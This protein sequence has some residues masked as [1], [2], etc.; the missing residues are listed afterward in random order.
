MIR[1]KSMKQRFAV[2]M[3]FPVGLSLLG[4]GWA[5]FT[6]ARNRML[7][8]WGEATI[9]KLQRAAHHVDMRLSK[10]KEMLNLFTASAGMPHAAGIQKLVI[11]RLRQFQW[12]ADVDLEW[13]RRIAASNEHPMTQGAMQGHAEAMKAGGRLA[14]TSSM[15]PFHRGS[16]VR[17]TSPR[18]DAVSGGETV[19]LLSELKNADDQTIGRIEVNLFFSHLIDVVETTGWWKAQKAFLVDGTGRILASNVDDPR[20]AL[21]GQDAAMTQAIL[22][23]T[24]TLPFGTVFGKGKPPQEVGGFYRLSE[25][26]WV[27]IVIAPGREI[28]SSIIDFRFY[29]FVFGSIFIGVILIIIRLVTGK[30]VAA[31]RGVSDAARTVAEGDYSVSLPVRSED[32][33]GD[34]IRSFNTM[35]GQLKERAR[36]K[37]SLNLASEVQ[38]NLFPEKGLQVST[39]DVAGRSISCD[40]TGG[41]YF[42]YLEGAEFSEDR[43]GI[44]VGDVS[45][46]GIAA[47]LLMT[48]ARALIRSRFMQGG[49][50]ADIVT[51]VNRLLCRDTARTSN[52]MTLFLCLVDGQSKDIRW[53]RAGHDPAILYDARK[54]LFSVLDGKGMA[55]GV[56]ETYRYDEFVHKGWYSGDILI[57]GTDGIWDTENPSGE[58]FGKARLREIVRRGSHETAERILTAITDALAAFRQDRVQEDDVTLVV[59]KA[60]KGCL[61]KRMNNG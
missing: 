11:Q 6:Y 56:D 2:Y 16:T 38:Q 23:A 19:S 50:L 20:L 32:E 24:Q 58:R 51:G 41:D 34:L 9:L 31:I 22:A 42:D 5:A 48:T 39:L 45:D 21:S 55:L 61:P 46:H 33:I 26:P 54:D 30:T 43:I 13:T 1:F 4:M 18:F 8:E 35:V 15:M 57:I 12:V 44:A 40:E 60:K 52:F 37:Y 36:M 3:L 25:A 10:P 49:K 17:I 7:A 59:V 29:Y 28:L 27:L 14:G 53:V 47:S